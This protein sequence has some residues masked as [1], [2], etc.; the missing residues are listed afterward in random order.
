[1]LPPNNEDTVYPPLIIKDS[2]PITDE[3]QPSVCDNHYSYPTL[4]RSIKEVFRKHTARVRIRV[5]NLEHCE[6]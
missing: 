6:F 4:E 3:P 5:S 1:M 2:A